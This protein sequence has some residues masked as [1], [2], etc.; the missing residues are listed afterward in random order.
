MVIDASAVKNNGVIFG[1]T[2]DTSDFVVDVPLAKCDCGRDVQL[3]RVINNAGVPMST[4]VCPRCG[5]V[6]SHRRVREEDMIDYWNRNS[7]YVTKD[8]RYMLINGDDLAT[9]IVDKELGEE[10]SFATEYPEELTANDWADSVLSNWYGIMK[11]RIF[12]ADVIIVGQFGGGF[13]S[14]V[15][16]I[17]NGC[18]YLGEDLSGYINET[19]EDGTTTENYVCLDTKACVRANYYEGIVNN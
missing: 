9:F 17:E 3:H 12:D 1:N 2:K 6:F 19:I 16:T 13:D 18:D 8:A 10:Y 4:I 7:E 11:T 15:F 14:R 5:V